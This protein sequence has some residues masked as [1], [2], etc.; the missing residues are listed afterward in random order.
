MFCDI[1]TCIS[2]MTHWT[3]PSNWQMHGFDRPIYTNT[4][5]PFP[6][7]PPFVPEENPTGCYRTYFHIPKEWKG[8]IYFNALAS[9]SDIYFSWCIPFL[10]AF[11]IFNFII[12]PK[13]ISN[14]LTDCHLLFLHRDYN[15][16][17]IFEIYLHLFCLPF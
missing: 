4:T 12:V 8:M 14:A 9:Y 5:Y 2:S 13:F 6:L 17:L 15:F 16:E 10:P 1:L 11:L 3:V 7:N